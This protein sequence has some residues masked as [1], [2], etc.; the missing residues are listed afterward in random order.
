MVSAQIERLQ[1]DSDNLSIYIKE[2]KQQGNERLM[3]MII[4]KKRYL[5]NRISEICNETIGR[6]ETA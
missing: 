6:L 2:L 4:Q 5:D 3:N 1:Q